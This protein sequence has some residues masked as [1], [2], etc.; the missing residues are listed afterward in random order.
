MFSTS[1]NEEYESKVLLRFFIILNPRL[2]CQLV[3]HLDFSD[4][5]LVRFLAS[6]F[7]RERLKEILEENIKL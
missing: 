3:K 6:L 2:A 5:I 1:T 4:T 7:W